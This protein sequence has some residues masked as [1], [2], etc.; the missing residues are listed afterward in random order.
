MAS[1]PITRLPDEL[2]Q[3]T[4]LNTLR[5]DGVTITEPDSVAE[6]LRAG[7]PTATLDVLDKLRE[8]KLKCHPQNNMKLMLV[9]PQVCMIMIINQGK[10]DW[11]ILKF[12]SWK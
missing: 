10:T 12:Y 8:R 3:L 5:L 1:N 6:L 11:E 4:N 7:G 9:G 2:A